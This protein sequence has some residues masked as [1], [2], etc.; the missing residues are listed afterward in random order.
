[1]DR[2]MTGAAFQGSHRAYDS[3]V[4]PDVSIPARDG[5]QLAADVYLPA[6]NGRPL[7]VAFPAIVER[8]PYLKDSV[9]YARRGHWY[10][11][12]GYAVVMNDVRGRGRSGG[13]W[14][15]F[16]KEA[17]DGFDT[18]EWVAV[19]PW[20][21][22]RVGT[23]GASY[24][25]SDQS[26]LATLSPPHLRAQVVGQGASNYLISSMRQGGALEQ[27]FISYAYRMAV[28]SQEAAADPDLARVL[29]AEFERVPEI[30]G[31]PL[32]FRPG[33]TALCLLPL[34]EQWAWDILTH[35]GRG[36]YWSQRGYTIDE[37]WDEHADVPVLFQSGW[38]D[39][40]PR[41][42][43][44]NYQ[45]LRRRKSSPMSLLL[46]HW[47]HGEQ[48]TEESSAGDVDLG[49]E[50]ALPLYDDLRLRFFDHHLKQLETGLNREPPVR[51]FVMGG[52]T[53]RS[54]ADLERRLWHGGR[55]ETANQWPPPDTAETP[56]YLHA[57]G[58]LSDAPPPMSADSTRFTYDPR[59]P[60]PTT[61]GSISAAEEALPSGGFDQRGQPGRFHGHRDTLSHASRPDVL[62]FETAPF[63]ESFEIAGPVEVVLFASS[64]ALDTDF[65]AKL[66]DVYPH[67]Q[68]TP[69]G[70]EL[71]L[72][73]SILRARYRNGL[74]REELLDPARS[75]SSASS[76]TPRPIASRPA[77]GYA[78]TSPRPTI[79]GST[80]TPTPASHWAC[81][82]ASRWLTNPCTTT[83]ST[84]A[85][86]SSTSGLFPHDSKPSSGGR[87][88]EQYV[89][90]IRLTLVLGDIAVQRVDA[91]VNAANSAL[92]GGGGVDGAIHRAGG[93]NIMAECRR[94]GGCPTGDAVRTTAGRLPADHVIHTVGP[95]WS[96]GRAGEPDL[97][98]SAYRRS[99]EV[100][101]AHG[102]R[103]V[104]FPSIS[105]GVYGY[106]K[107]QAAETALDAVT[108]ALA[109]LDLDE[110]RFV[111]FGADDRAIY[112]QA[113]R[114]RLGG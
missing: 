112:Q 107:T 66:L 20:C 59:N 11:R 78:W 4:L 16:A 88:M 36:A 30:L 73:D 37:Y 41:G 15:P 53:G 8:T 38:Y 27:R 97:L 22:G 74:D 10:A 49:L 42:A 71:N 47:R 106:P 61:G 99:L 39:T 64:S 28:S 83:P 56:L 45:A 17:P 5:V 98:S 113:M 35:G 92:R 75:T 19:Q 34:Y 103:T 62:S 13:Q 26:A 79:P 109:Q 70:Y 40:Y 85:A 72:A 24:A 100:A 95:V 57:D 32:R 48:T 102:A 21:N 60:V 1:M 14:Y 52:Q 105:T 29:L 9:R 108:A 110:V 84:P 6:L 55:W 33:R 58:S 96:G 54:P 111:V 76:S 44:A 101:A 46:G 94:I 2:R 86:C 89:G 91:I 67:S 63:D 104:A 81:R 3:V 68:A 12:R 23:M 87:V 93:P 18:V 69:G 77:T 31:P 43:T 82:G 50:S 7:D 90:T 114:A 80:P 65:T 51:Y 25:G